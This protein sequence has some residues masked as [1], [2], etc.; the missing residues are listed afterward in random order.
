MVVTPIRTTSLEQFLILPETKPASEY[1]DGKIVQKPMP[2]GK[3]SLLRMNILT[4]INSILMEAKIAIAF[5]ELRCT[6]GG[7]STV[8]DVVILEN[9]NIP[10]DDDGEISNV[11]TTPPN[12]IIEILSPDQSTTKVIKNIIHCLE[13]GTED[14]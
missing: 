13:C 8:P 11:V 3:H 2:Q 4:F 12:W 5:P 7:R 1:I 10:K 6:I 14:G 9:K